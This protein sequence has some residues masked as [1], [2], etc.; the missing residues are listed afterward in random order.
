V[1]I[2]SRKL[3]ER[4]YNAVH[5]FTA[6]DYHVGILWPLYCLSTNLRLLITTL[7]SS[8]HCIVCPSIY[9]SDYHFGIIKFF[10]NKN[11]SEL[12][13]VETSYYY[14]VCRIGFWN[15]SNGVFFFHFILEIR[16]VCSQY[17]TD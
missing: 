10:D 11:I 2:R 16:I 14:N 17:C 5:Q 12:G 1:V 8:V 13:V 3:V 6:S 7:V 15:C 4:Q 9:G